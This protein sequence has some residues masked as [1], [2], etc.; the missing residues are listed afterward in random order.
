ME[1]VKK[2]LNPCD[3]RIESKKITL[4]FKV[5][6]IVSSRDFTYIVLQANIEGWGKKVEFE[7]TGDSG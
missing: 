2:I 1:K 7:K 5:L 4:G 3:S 6:L